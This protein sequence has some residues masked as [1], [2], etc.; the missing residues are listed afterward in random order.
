MGDMCTS[1]YTYL[2]ISWKGSGEG[3]G[4]LPCGGLIGLRDDAGLCGLVRVEAQGLARVPELAAPA[5]S[6]RAMAVISAAARSGERIRGISGAGLFFGLCPPFQT[7][8]NM[9]S[10][11]GKKTAR[12]G[13]PE[14]RDEVT[15]IGRAHV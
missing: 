6:G 13:A 12:P 7:G 14:R 10:Y 15:E 1:G 11:Q 9:V 4:A 5:S 3:A 2:K 8:E